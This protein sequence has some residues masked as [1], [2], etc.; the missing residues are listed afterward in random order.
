MVEVFYDNEIW[1][2]NLL[3]QLTSQELANQLYDA[4][5]NLGAGR[6]IRW[7]QVLVNVPGDGKL[8]PQTVAA[9]NND[10]DPSDLVLSF[11]GMRKAEYQKIVANNSVDEKFLQGWLNRC[12]LS[13]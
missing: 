13:V 1:K 4:I 12:V 5:V 10:R 8:G 3:W 2:A 7:V 6:P 9:C 11:I